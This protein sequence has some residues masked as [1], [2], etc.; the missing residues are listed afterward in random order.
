[1]PELVLDHGL[2]TVRK[3][4][5]HSIHVLPGTPCIQYVVHT[6]NALQSMR[7]CDP[8]GCFKDIARVCSGQVHC[9]VCKGCLHFSSC[10]ASYPACSIVAIVLGKQKRFQKAGHGYCQ[11]LSLQTSVLNSGLAC[12]SS[13]RESQ[14]GKD[15]ARFH[16]L[17]C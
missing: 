14:G 17:S 10:V 16:R 3:G 15:G 1:M 13:Q 7:C 6:W 2:R 11:S 4:A 5:T 8:L 12:Q 9:I